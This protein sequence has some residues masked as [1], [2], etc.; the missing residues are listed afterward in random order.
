MEPRTESRELALGG[1]MGAAALLLPAVFHLVHLGFLFMPMYMPLCLLAF[2]VGPRIAATTA[3]ITPLISGLLTS[4]PPLYPPIAPVMSVELALM[5]GA[6]ALARTRWPRCNE[7]LL[8]FPVL[9]AGR[10]LNFFLMYAVAEIMKLPPGFVATLS[11]VAGWPGVALML[12]VI[13]ALVRILKTKG[14][15]P[16]QD[17]GH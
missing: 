3:F 12:A 8:L 4:M 9:L 2:L 16:G 14:T 13:P 15:F 11:F 7:W 10:I 6:I 1:L 5:C 17:P